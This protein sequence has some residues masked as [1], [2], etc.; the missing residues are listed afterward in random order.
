MTMNERI[1]SAANHIAFAMDEGEHNGM[2][3]EE[4]ESLDSLFGTMFHYLNQKQ[5]LDL[6]GKIHFPE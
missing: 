6:Y 3:Q 4:W 2:S 5:G 1:I